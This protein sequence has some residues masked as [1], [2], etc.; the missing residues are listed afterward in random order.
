MVVQTATPKEDAARPAGDV[1]RD[2]YEALDAGQTRR[3]LGMLAGEAEWIEA[4]GSPYG[5]GGAF[6]GR[7]AVWEGLLAPLEAEWDR[8]KMLREDFV[9]AT[10]SRTELFLDVN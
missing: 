1:V 2:F 10:L 3:A 9:E 6:H 4:E 7:G 5:A 8:L